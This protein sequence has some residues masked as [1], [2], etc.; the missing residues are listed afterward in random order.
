MVDGPADTT[1]DD[2]LLAR[3]EQGR[4][5]CDQCPYCAGDDIQ[6]WGKA[7]GKPRY[8][9]KSCR[10]TFNALTGTPLARL[11]H[12]DR[13]NDQIRALISGEPVAKAAER[14]NVDYVTAFRWRRR[15][16]AALDPGD[17]NSLASIST[18][19]KAFIVESFN[20]K[21][22]AKGKRGDPAKRRRRRKLRRPIVPLE[23]ASPPSP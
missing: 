1:Q 23:Q 11:H 18:A 2:S 20:T 14:C 9:C 13:W 6:R 19:D 16:L 21:R 3:V 15:F 12:R 10:K 4:M 17:P 5:A 7:G 22:S 8:R